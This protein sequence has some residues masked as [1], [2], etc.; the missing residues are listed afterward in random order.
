MTLEL[1]TIQYEFLYNK[2]N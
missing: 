1:E 2:T